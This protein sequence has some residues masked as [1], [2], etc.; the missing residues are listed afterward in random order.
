MT[1]KSARHYG[2]RHGQWV[3][4]ARASWQIPEQTI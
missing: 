1:D 2:R 3:W 4:E